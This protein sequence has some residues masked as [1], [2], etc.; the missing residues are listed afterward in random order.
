MSNIEL[1]KRVR[2]LRKF[3]GWSVKELASKANMSSTF[4]YQLEQGKQNITVKY[5]SRLCNTLEISL[6]EFFDYKN[7]SGEIEETLRLTKKQREHLNN[8]IRSLK[9]GTDLF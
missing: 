3:R 6:A 8:F 4:I 5:L 9:R 2:E 7:D 1:G